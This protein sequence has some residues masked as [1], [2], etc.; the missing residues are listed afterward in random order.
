MR[1][2]VERRRILHAIDADAFGRLVSRLGAARGYGAPYG[3]ALMLDG[4]ADAWTEGNVS[5]WNI[6]PFVVL[7]EEAG[8][9]FTDLNG[10]R[11]WP[12]RSGLAAAPELHRALL[13]VI[14]GL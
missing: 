8:A 4:Q 3:V 9:R 5:P 11:A 10:E 1:T 14:R 13:G 12:C 2:V 7:F 6:A